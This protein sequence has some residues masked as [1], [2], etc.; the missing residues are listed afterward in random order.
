[1]TVISPDSN[2]KV[3][4]FN[5]MKFKFLVGVLFYLFTS[6]CFAAAELV[7]VG[8][9][10]KYGR[11][12]IEVNCDDRFAVVESLK[13]A[14]FTL[15]R[16][17]IGGTLEDMCWDAFNDAKDLHP[18]ISF[19]GITDSFFVRCNMGLEYVK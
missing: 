10:V 19:A 16:N 8:Q 17:N 15:R 5:Y 18:S 9:Q 3:S 2:R 13:Q 7:C 1:M 6:S 12:G 14:W 11:T 4:V